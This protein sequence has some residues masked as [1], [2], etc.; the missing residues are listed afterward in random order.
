VVRGEAGQV[1]TE[2]ASQPGDVLVIGS[3]RRGSMRRVACRVSRYCLG[4]SSC[5]VVAVPP[6]RLAEEAGGL[7]WF[8]LRRKLVRSGAE[9]HT[10]DA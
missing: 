3:G 7:R 1:L 9:L 6:S 2:V 4:H 8:V 10:A 5:P